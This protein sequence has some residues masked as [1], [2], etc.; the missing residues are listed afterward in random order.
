MEYPKQIIL[1][2]SDVMEMIDG[3]Q[4]VEMPSVVNI[5]KKFMKRVMELS[6]DLIYKIYIT[7]LSE[8]EVNFIERTF[9]GSFIFIF[10]EKVGNWFLVTPFNKSAWKDE[11]VVMIDEN[12]IKEYLE[13]LNKA[14]QENSPLILVPSNEIN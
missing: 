3:T 7:N 10:S 8:E 13:C 6:D 5:D 9:V 1:P 11:M 12:M 4:F 2:F 14:E